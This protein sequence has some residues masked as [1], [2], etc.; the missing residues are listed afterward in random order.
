MSFTPGQ[1]VL[2]S[3]T[4]SVL[5]ECD[6]IDNIA[7]NVCIVVEVDEDDAEAFVVANEGDEE[8]SYIPFELLSPA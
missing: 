1:K 7:G 2:V 6:E 4:A 3:K 8:G 5:V